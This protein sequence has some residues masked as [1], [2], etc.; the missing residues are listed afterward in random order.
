MNKLG[1]ARNSELPKESV[2]DGVEIEKLSSK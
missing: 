2:T 1:A